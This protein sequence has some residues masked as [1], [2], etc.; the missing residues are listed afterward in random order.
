MGAN[1]AAFSEGQYNFNVGKRKRLKRRSTYGVSLNRSNFHL[2][3]EV[4]MNKE[5]R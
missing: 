5:Y 2:P 1:I 3:N 4:V